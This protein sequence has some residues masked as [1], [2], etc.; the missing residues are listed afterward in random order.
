MIK[1]EVLTVPLEAKHA[2]KSRLL[3][4]L[5]LPLVTRRLFRP[6]GQRQV[7]EPTATRN[8]A[9]ARVLIEGVSFFRQTAERFTVSSR[10]S[11]ADLKLTICTGY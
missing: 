7:T 6:K 9:A 8:R 11:I 3:R 4:S 10:K 5:V 1:R 2:Y